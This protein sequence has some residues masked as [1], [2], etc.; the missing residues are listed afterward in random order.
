MYIPTRTPF[1]AYSA[2]TSTAHTKQIHT[3]GCTGGTGSA[4]SL[5][6]PAFYTLCFPATSDVTSFSHHPEPNS[7][8]PPSPL[9]FSPTSSLPLVAAR[10]KDAAVA[11]AKEARVEPG[12]DLNVV[13]QR[14]K[15]RTVVQQGDV[16][17]RRT[18][19]LPYATHCTHRPTSCGH[20]RK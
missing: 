9:P 14:M 3:K 17:V 20:G 13:E 10:H 16:K 15:I 1:A 8:F 11:F 2:P 6:F 19:F 5:F 7:P 4:A 18:C 12:A